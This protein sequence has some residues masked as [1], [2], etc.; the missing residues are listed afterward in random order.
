MIDSE[1]ELL[2][3][4]PPDLFLNLKQTAVGMGDVIFD[5]LLKLPVL[6]LD[7]LANG[8][9]PTGTKVE[10]LVTIPS[11][12]LEAHSNEQRRVMNLVHTD[13]GAFAEAWNE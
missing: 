7:P 8:D 9:P 1:R 2:G 12:D 5:A 4:R 3:H 10:I 11:P 6:L 13:P